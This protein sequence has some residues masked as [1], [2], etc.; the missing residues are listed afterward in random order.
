MWW[1]PD[2][3]VTGRE[4]VGVTAQ[5]R[6]G[7]RTDSED[8]ESPCV[9]RTVPAGG[10]G[11]SGE[12]QGATTRNG[13]TVTA[14]PA[15]QSPCRRVEQRRNRESPVQCHAMERARMPLGLSLMARARET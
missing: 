5:R 15:A 11:R 14:P 6:S 9:G 1:R 13:G 8:R 2:T 4:V 12:A 3:V 10:A 7:E